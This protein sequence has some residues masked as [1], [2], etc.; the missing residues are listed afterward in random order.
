MLFAGKYPN[1]RHPNIL[2]QITRIPEGNFQN[3]FQEKKTI[4]IEIRVEKF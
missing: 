3:A 2:K 4:K 1:G